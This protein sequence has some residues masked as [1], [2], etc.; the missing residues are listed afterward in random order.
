LLWL[1]WR[2]VVSL[3]VQVGLDH[4]PP[5]LHFPLAGM[6]GT[7]LLIEMGSREHCAH[8]CL[9]LLLPQSQPPK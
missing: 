6:T 4:D 1:F 5:I 3:F 7:Q 9:E 8:A 2:W